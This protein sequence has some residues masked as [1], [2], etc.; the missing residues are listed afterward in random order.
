MSN[1][2]YLIDFSKIGDYLNGYISVLEKNNLPFIPKRI[3]WTYNT[4]ENLVRGNHAHFQLEQI[5][6]AVSGIIELKLEMLDG[7]K[8]EFVLNKPNLG[9]FIPKMAWHSMKYFDKAV[10]VCI[11]NMEYQEEDYIRSYDDFK[12][13]TSK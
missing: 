1:I 13:I 11:A 9:V 5:L 7:E 10:Q 4:S 6:I 2:P 12:K 8:I 3:Y